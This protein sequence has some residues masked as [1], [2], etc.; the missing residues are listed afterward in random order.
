MSLWASRFFGSVSSYE[1]WSAHP[2]RP[3]QFTDGIVFVVANSR[4]F[5]LV[6]GKVAAIL[7]L[8]PS[9]SSI[10]PRTHT[11]THTRTHAHTRAHAHKG[12]SRFA[13]PGSTRRRFCITWL[14]RPS[15]SPE[16]HQARLR[17]ELP[18]NAP[19]SVFPVLLLRALLLLLRLLPLP[20]THHVRSILLSSSGLGFGSPPSHL[21]PQANLWSEATYLSVP[22]PTAIYPF[23]QSRGLDKHSQ[24]FVSSLLFLLSLCSSPKSHALFIL[25]VYILLCAEAVI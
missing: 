19:S 14:L 4:E 25:P 13:N 1:L 7:S 6:L 21:H 15:I 17:S 24:N 2:T 20:T 8:P 11:Y 12:F 23:P 5:S 22:P 16:S 9:Y 10:A 18:A 3:P